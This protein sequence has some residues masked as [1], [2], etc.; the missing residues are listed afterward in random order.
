MFLNN[1]LIVSKQVAILYILVALG[2]V[3]D[4]LGI[5]KEKTARLS[6][7]LLFYI[8]TPAVMIRAFMEVDGSREN[9]KNLLVAAGLGAL[10]QTLGAV[11]AQVFFRDKND[12]DNCVY[13]L[14]TAYGNVGYM[15]LPLAQA[16]FGAQGVF[17]CSGVVMVFNVFNFTHGI[18]IVSGGEKFELKKLILNPGTIAVLIGLPFLIFRIP[19]PEI[20]AKPMDYVASLQTPLAMIFF[21]TYLANTDLKTMFSN[22][23]IYRATFLKLIAT[24]LIMLAFMK[25][26]GVGKEM[27]SAILISSSAPSANMTVMFSAKYGKDV[28]LASKL[29]ALCSFISI[30]TMPVMIA[31]GSMFFN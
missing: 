14:A 8:I 13:K 4:R 18:Q 15:A 6:N 10:L 19:V 9:I 12:P 24:P 26:V 28:G 25:L 31:F 5:F 21:G 22:L 23:K 11:L 17:F 27:A 16:M 7:D 3:V 20:V 2:F 1:L 29:V 30:I